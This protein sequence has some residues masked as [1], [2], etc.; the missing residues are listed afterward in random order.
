MRSAHSATTQDVQS[1][2]LAWMHVTKAEGCAVAPMVLL[3][4]TGT[5][6]LCRKILSSSLFQD[7]VETSNCGILNLHMAVEPIT[8]P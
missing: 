7:V 4:S 5:S 3:Q 1:D 6:V 2:N 8:Q